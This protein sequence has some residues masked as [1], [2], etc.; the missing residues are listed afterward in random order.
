MKQRLPAYTFTA[1]DAYVL[2]ATLYVTANPVFSASLVLKGVRMVV[3]FY[4]MYIPR[5]ISF[6]EFR[7]FHILQNDENFAHFEFH[8]LKIFVTSEIGEILNCGKNKKSIRWNSYLPNT[9]SAENIGMPVT[10]T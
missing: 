7:L 10:H 6:A 9:K 8:E 1:L 4:Q 3:H 2:T 5:N